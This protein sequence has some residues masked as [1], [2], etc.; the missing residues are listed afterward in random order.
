[1]SEALNDP[2]YDIE[3]ETVVAAQMIREYHGPQWLIEHVGSPSDAEDLAAINAELWCFTKVAVQGWY[4][5]TNMITME[6]GQTY[7]VKFAE[8]HPCDGCEACV[9]D[10]DVDCP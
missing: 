1:M 10:P 6:S 2:I 5:Y 3:Q 9:K 8:T 4:P 7:L